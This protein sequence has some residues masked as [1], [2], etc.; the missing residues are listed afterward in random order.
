MK[1]GSIVDIKIAKSSGD[2]NL[3]KESLRV[4]TAMP[5]WIPGEQGGEAVN[6]RFT[7]PVSFRLQ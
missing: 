5:K 3:D 6:V 7:Q 2:E 4:V 1:D